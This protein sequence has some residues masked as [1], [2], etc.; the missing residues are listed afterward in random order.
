MSELGFYAEVCG[1]CACVLLILLYSIKR[2]PTPQLKFGLFS[3]LVFWHIIYFFSDAL[4]ALVN[5]G[6]IAKNF[7][8][9]LAA[10]YSNAVIISILFY[11]CFVFAEISSRPEMTRAQIQ[12]LQTKLRIPIV[13][14]AVFLL[15]SFVAVPKFWLKENLEPNDLYY[16]VLLFLPFVYIMTPTFRCFSRVLKPQNRK[17]LKTYLVVASYVPCSIVAASL[18]VFYSLNAPIFCF[19]CTLIILFVY[20][21]LQSQLI[22][23]D[24]LTSLNNRNQLE[25]FLQQQSEQKSYYVVMVDIDHFKQINDT[26]GH[27]EGDNALVLVSSALKKACNRLGKSVFLCRYGGDEFLL[28]V[29]TDMPGYAVREIQ[30]C[31]REELSTRQGPQY[32][33]I[34]VSIGYAGWDGRVSSFKDSVVNADQMMYVEKCSA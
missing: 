15:V 32:Y 5:D 7:I 3:K 33:A 10:N 20:L 13:I 21:N 18:Q 1:G 4:W 9:V 12:S 30:E 23:T 31:L 2:L 22:S 25:V 24:S 17:N 19:G 6:V 8:S 16:V 28:V 26:Y 27:I 14:E 11:S 29:P 34:E